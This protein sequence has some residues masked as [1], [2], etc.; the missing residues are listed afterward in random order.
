MSDGLERRI[1][2]YLHDPAAGGFGELALEL[3]AEQFERLP[4]YR[5]EC[6]RL[7]AS[8]DGLESWRDVPAV[9]VPED[10]RLAPTSRRVLELA[11]PSLFEPGPVS[12]IVGS[13]EASSPASTR[14]I[15]T[16]A[17]VAPEQSFLSP[18]P[19]PDSRALRSWLGTRQRDRRPV[20]LIATG[21][22][23]HGLIDT[24]ERRSLKFR[25]P[26]GSKSFVV[27]T[28]ESAGVSEVGEPSD[29]AARASEWLGLAAG[30]V[31]SL[32][33]RPGATPLLESALEPGCFH[34]PHWV[35]AGG[36]QATPLTLFD[37]ASLGA[38]AH[39][40]APAEARLA[41]GKRIVFSR[42]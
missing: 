40:V 3:F 4:S 33:T 1:E 30:E 31:R 7:G 32:L 41:D 35:R 15:A 2:E 42:S 13:E 18:R 29:H 28:A 20:R 38:P 19:R 23:H 8:P 6:E 36:G 37:L 26:P 17:E 14:L 5:S 27:R 24:L 22:G 21:T 11:L 12:L 34:L 10:E 16:L 9:S 39:A 25:L